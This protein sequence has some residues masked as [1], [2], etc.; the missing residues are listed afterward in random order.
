[1]SKVIVRFLA[2]LGALWLVGMAIV[3]FAVLRTKG[4]VPSK[5]ILEANFDRSFPEEIPD[6]PPPVSWRPIAKRCEA[7]STPSTAAPAT[8]VWSE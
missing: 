2:I 6:T 8:I 7:S 1:M 4:T 3:L 5:T